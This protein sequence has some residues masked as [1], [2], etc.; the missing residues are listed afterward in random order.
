MNSDVIAPPEDARLLNTLIL[1]TNCLVVTGIK[2]YEVSNYSIRAK[3]LSH[4]SN[5]WKH[6]NYLGLGPGAHS[7]W[8][9]EKAERW[10]NEEDLR[11]YLRDED[12][13][14]REEL[15][16]KQLAEERLMMGLST[17]R[18]WE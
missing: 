10:E 13:P 11:K 15:T 2:R 1:L 3:R 14:E 8:W 6:E 4:N 12:Q 18:E 7:F 5:Y 16:L 17:K 9:D